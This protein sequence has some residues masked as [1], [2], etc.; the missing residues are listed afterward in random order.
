MN[1][2][3]LL[4]WLFGLFSKEPNA[5]VKP[6][7][8]E[9]NK[10]YNG[11]D[12]P[13]VNVRAVGFRAPY[14]TKIVHEVLSDRVEELHIDALF[15]AWREYGD[16]VPRH[17]AYILATVWHECKFQPG[18]ERRA[19]PY[20]QPRLWKLQERYWPS[21]YYGRGYV[22]L[23]WRKNYERFSRLLGM[24]LVKDPDLVNRPHIG[25]AITVIGMTEGYFTGRNLSYYLDEVPPDWVNA[26]R[27]V[28]GTDK[29]SE[30]AATAQRIYNTYQNNKGL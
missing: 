5:I 26:R 13:V 16:Q 15:S 24:D 3:L 1:L 11:G 29:A 28:N 21:G 9:D 23:T 27:V 20:R 19:S 12:L 18:P 14:W 6:E 22:Q 30:I 2:I 7:P 10:L 25:A 4:N 17:F 8:C